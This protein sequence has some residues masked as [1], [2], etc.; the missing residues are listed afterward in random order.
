MSRF[1]FKTLIMKGWRV[2]AWRML[3]AKVETA[4]S[5]HNN[6]PVKQQ[7]LLLSH[8]FSPPSLPENAA[9]HFANR[10][11]TPPM[12]RLQEWFCDFPLASLRPA[13]M[14][15]SFFMWF[16]HS[17][18]QRL[19]VFQCY[20]SCGYYAVMKG[21]L[22]VRPCFSWNTEPT[23]LHCSDSEAFISSSANCNRLS[24]PAVGMTATAVTFVEKAFY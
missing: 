22:T 23:K 17:Y 10:W 16:N 21:C 18:E 1:F 19:K 13:D 24:P 6:E 8:F 9:T 4:A 2:S 14:R 5:S 3:I 12:S 11:Q 7:V 20:D 15:F